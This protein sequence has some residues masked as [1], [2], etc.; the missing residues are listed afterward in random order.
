MIILA[1]DIKNF[2]LVFLLIVQLVSGV[3]LDGCMVGIFYQKMIRPTKYTKAVRFSKRAVICQRDGRLCLIFRLVDHRQHHGIKTKVKAFIFREKVSLEGESLGQ[4]QARLKLVSNGKL[5][6][7][8]P[9]TVCHF[10]DESSPLYHYSAKSLLESRFEICVSITG[11]SRK[12]GQTVQARTSYLSSEILWGQRFTNI[13]EYDRDSEEYVADYNRFDETVAVSMPLCSAK[14]LDEL[15]KD[16]NYNAELNAL[17]DQEIKEAENDRDLDNE[18]QDE[19]NISEN[20][21]M[22]VVSLVTF[23]L[24]SVKSFKWNPSFQVDD[25]QDARFFMNRRITRTTS[26]VQNYQGSDEAVQDQYI[27]KSLTDIERERIRV[28][29]ENSRRLRKYQPSLQT[30]ELDYD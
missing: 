30:M 29:K 28:A 15:E 3:L 26:V 16:M 11:D 24:L 10:I 12:T 25:L 23:S 17:R 27:T 14:R 20:S 18:D 6:L 1:K 2:H 8:W 21:D 5:F 19:E 13:I 4:C 22:D 9:E 7:L